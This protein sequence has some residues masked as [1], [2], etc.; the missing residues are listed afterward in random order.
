MS[1]FRLGQTLPFFALSALLAFPVS[2]QARGDEARYKILRVDDA[3]AT[4]VDVNSITSSFA[5]KY[6]TAWMYL[7]AEDL[8]LLDIDYFESQV[9]FDCSL[10]RSEEILLRRFKDGVG[11]VVNRPRLSES[12]II[13]ESGTE[14]VFEFV[15]N[16]KV[17]SDL[18]GLDLIS[19]NE[20]SEL[21]SIIRADF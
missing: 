18:Q 17:A 2:A 5:G 20:I 3:G 1:M 12:P 15:C 6:K 19:R 10:R 9:K 8:L 4:L 7:L 16:G 21:N 13:P 14:V 11:D